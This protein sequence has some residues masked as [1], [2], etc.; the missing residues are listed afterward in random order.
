[1]VVKDF[2]TQLRCFPRPA[3]LIVSD[4]SDKKLRP[5]CVRKEDDK[6]IIDVVSDSIIA[7][8]QGFNSLDSSS[9]KFKLEE[10]DR[11]LP[12]IIS[13]YYGATFET[14]CVR[15]SGPDSI[16]IDMDGVFN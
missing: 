12:V 4:Y 10:C 16:A 7:T 5:C 14:T 1:L 13:D 8:N 15:Q 9:L 2:I 11:N 3:E 6:I